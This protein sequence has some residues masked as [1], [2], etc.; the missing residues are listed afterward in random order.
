MEEG[1][2]SEIR[3][4]IKN[5][6]N[7]IFENAIAIKDILQSLNVKAISY[8]K[9]RDSD[10]V[11]IVKDE[12]DAKIIAKNE[13]FAKETIHIQDQHNQELALVIFDIGYDRAT[14]NES[15]LKSLGVDKIISPLTSLGGNNVRGGVKEQHTVK[16]IMSDKQKRDELLSLVFVRIAEF[17]YM[18]EPSF[19]F[20]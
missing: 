20:F 14:K 9:G 2:N 7:K 3:V 5:P 4:I 19:F 6:R 17:D 11:I 16:V 15:Y 8:R 13:L 12:Q 10:K 18:I 1:R